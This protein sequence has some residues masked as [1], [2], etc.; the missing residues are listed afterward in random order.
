MIIQILCAARILGRIGH[1]MN[2]GFYLSIRYIIFLFSTLFLMIALAACNIPSGSPAASLDLTALAQTAEIQLTQIAASLAATLNQNVTQP[3]VTPTPII[4]TPTPS[5]QNTG[6]AFPAEIP[7]DRAGA[8][9]MLDV[10]Y[11]DDSRLLPGQQFTK[12]WRLVNRGSCTWNRNYQVV[13]FSG[14]R[15][16]VSPSQPL[17]GKVEPGESV[18]IAVDMLAPQQP[19]LYTSYWMLRNPEGKLFGIG[20][21]GNAPF[22]AR[23]QVIAIYTSTPTATPTTTPTPITLA[24]G[25]FDLGLG[26]WVDLDLGELSGDEEKADIRLI[27]TDEGSIW[28]EVFGNAGLMIFGEVQPSVNDCRSAIFSTNR[29][30]VESIPEGTFLCYRTNQGLSGSLR[31]VSISPSPLTIRFDFLTWAIP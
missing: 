12:I 5:L 2:D 16:G 29:I 8:G 15:L 6:T 20:P 11:P 1:A 28:V 18:D 24:S 7:C 25:R 17:P 27:Q 3:A 30:G 4:L 14:D 26:E 13:W 23:I 31:V 21:G 19:G 22:W 10:T 9:S